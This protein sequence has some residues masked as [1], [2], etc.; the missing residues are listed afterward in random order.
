[1]SDILIFF[2]TL[3]G[4]RAVEVPMTATV[5][6][7]SAAIAESL[8]CEKAGVRLSY[9][10]THLAHRDETLADLGIGPQCCVEVV[11]PARGFNR[12]LALGPRFGAVVGEDRQ[13]HV[14]G[15]IAES[16]GTLHGVSVAACDDRLVVLSED[17]TARVQD[18][19]PHTTRQAPGPPEVL[20]VDGAP[21]QLASIRARG[22]V[23]CGVTADYSKVVL[24]NKAEDGLLVY[25]GGDVAD[26]VVLGVDI[27]CGAVAVV[28]LTS[29]AILL[30]YAWV[31]D[32][33]G[34]DEEKWESIC[35]AGD[36]AATTRMPDRMTG[37]KALCDGWHTAG[38]LTHADE[39][40]LYGSPDYRKLEVPTGHQWKVAAL[41]YDHCLGIT[42]EGTIKCWGENYDG[43]C[44]PPDLKLPAVAVA[45]GNLFSAAVLQ[46]GSVVAWGCND[47]AEASP[48]HVTAAVDLIPKE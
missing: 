24:W 19:D 23:I 25:S 6:E 3:E 4:Q 30:K 15:D 41:G 13:I 28:L 47:D 16:I 20:L 44:V 42:A 18:V 31:P 32:V 21:A 46:D 17:G 37:V 9:Q 7:L 12:I 36:D 22:G 26:A 39:L 43:C 8:G 48:P 35:G 34:S 40:F 2:T 33:D 29:G 45:G 38:I 10:C 1:M 11:P 14:W 27:S 5:G